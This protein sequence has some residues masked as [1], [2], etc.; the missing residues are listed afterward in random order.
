MTWLFGRRRQ[1]TVAGGRGR[2]GAAQDAPGTYVLGESEAEISRLNF[3][4]YMFRYAFGEDYSAPI[5]APRD[6]LDVASGTGRWAR[7]IARRFPQ[8]NVVGFDINRDL[9]E[10]SLAEGLDVMPENC[11]FAHGDAL[12]RFPFQDGL[13]DFVMA[14]ACSSFIPAAQWPQVIGEMIRVTRPGGWIEVRDFGLAQSNNAALNQ[15][16]VKFA[17]LAQGLGLHPG[18]GPFLK[19]YISAGRLRDVRVKN[20]LVRSGVR[21]GTRAGQ[22]GLI[23]YLAL[24]ERFT[25]I[26]ERAGVDSPDHWQMLLSQARTETRAYPDTNFVEVELTAAYGR[27]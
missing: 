4:H 26:V 20:I 8:A 18:A 7:E 3:Q 9:L 27:R 15:L 12:Q 17:T 23:D 10:A 13:F 24:L 22:L 16:T 5:R 21:R 11:A 2:R 25:P 14:R 6:I 1:A 19:Q